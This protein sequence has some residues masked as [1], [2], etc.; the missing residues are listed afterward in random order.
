MLG[1]QEDATAAALCYL[2]IGFKTVDTVAA[3][4]KGTPASGVLQPGDVITAVDG[5][6]VNCHHDVVTMIRHRKPGAPSR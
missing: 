4:A 5:Q 3:T 2:N 1:S 6:P